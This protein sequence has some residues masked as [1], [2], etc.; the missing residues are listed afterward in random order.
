MDK[1]QT[2]IDYV[3]DYIIDKTEQYAGSGETYHTPEGMAYG[4][5][6][7]DEANG[8]ILMDEDL[9]FKAVCDWREE[10]GAYV[11]RCNEDGVPFDNP[12]LRPGL[13][14]VRLVRFGVADVLR[15][16]TEN[17]VIPDGP[18]R[19]DDDLAEAVREGLEEIA[20][21]RFNR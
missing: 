12:F 20:D 5:T 2:M 1:N 3:K 8:T 10:A 15:Q 7:Y 21:F 16:L 11:S 17:G 14:M 4:L 18:F 13:F 6:S 19:L 9:S